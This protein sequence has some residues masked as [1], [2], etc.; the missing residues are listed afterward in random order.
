MIFL[1]ILIDAPLGQERLTVI[2]IEYADDII[3]IATNIYVA[4]RILWAVKGF[5][6]SL[7]S[8]STRINKNI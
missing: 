5:R 8:Y 7:D 6:S 1:I 3:L 4:N 2:L